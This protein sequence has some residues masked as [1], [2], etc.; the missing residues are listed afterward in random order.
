MTAFTPPSYDNAPDTTW[1]TADL[2]DLALNDTSLALRI[3]PQGYQTFGGCRWYF[4]EALTVT[5]P[6]TGG[7]MSL[8]PV[9]SQAGHRR[10]LV[11][12]A[13]G[14]SAQAILGD[15]MVAMAVQNN[16]SGII[17]NGFVRDTRVIARMPIGVHA[18]GAVPNR[19]AVMPPAEPTPSITLHGFTVTSGDW[20]YADEDG[21]IVL[22]R[23]HTEAVQ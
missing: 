4:G 3:F 17:I 10:V 9:L 11:V 12:D 21:V 13:E 14:S 1:S 22:A 8:A 7:A 16:W 18:L 2:C 6:H 15:R 23:R 20:I 5:A 19:A